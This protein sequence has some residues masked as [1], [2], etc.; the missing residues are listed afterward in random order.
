MYALYVKTV[1][2]NPWIQK[3]TQAWSLVLGGTGNNPEHWNLNKEHFWYIQP[4]AVFSD[5]QTLYLSVYPCTFV[6]SVVCK[7]WLIEFNWY[8]IYCLILNL[9]VI[10]IAV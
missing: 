7:K 6:H 10:I 2:F 1:D 5:F 3:N 4:L 9:N 8:C